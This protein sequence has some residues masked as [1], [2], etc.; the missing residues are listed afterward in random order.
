MSCVRC[1][2][3]LRVAHPAV[4]VV[5]RVLHVARCAAYRSI[6]TRSQSAP[7]TSPAPKSPACVG[8]PSREPIHAAAP[9]L[10]PTPA[11][12][13]PPTTAALPSLAAF[14]TGVG[15][16]APCAFVLDRPWTERRLR[17]AA[18]DGRTGGRARR[19]HQIQTGAAPSSARPAAG[20][21][22]D[23]AAAVS[24]NG[25]TSKQEMR[26]AATAGGRAG[27]RALL[28]CVR[29]VVCRQLCVCARGARVRVCA[30]V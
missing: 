10:G 14:L 8:V 22:G 26:A 28:V 17:T 24:G 27:G 25:P 13:P 4:H 15:R 7:R 3:C 23:G 11:L 18:A 29:S 20:F 6:S 12:T 30:C 2:A 21:G 9:P 19:R 16:G 5:R 1:G